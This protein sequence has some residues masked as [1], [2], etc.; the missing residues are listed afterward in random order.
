VSSCRHAA[1]MS[2]DDDGRITAPEGGGESPNEVL[3]ALEA[4]RQRGGF[5]GMI[6]GIIAPGIGPGV[7]LFIC[8]ALVLLIGLSA[9][10]VMAGYYSSHM[11]VMIFLAVGLMGSVVWSYSVRS[12]MEREHARDQDQLSYDQADDAK[13]EEEN[14][15]SAAGTES[16]SASAAAAGGAAAAP[17]RRSKSG[18]AKKDE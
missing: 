5:L 8:S 13:N 16:S 1:I 11:L 7:V 14:D 6:A 2:S 12:A 10:A 4:L 9:V 3:G 15:S 18:R 17:A